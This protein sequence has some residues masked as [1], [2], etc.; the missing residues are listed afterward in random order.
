MGT[1]MYFDV[2]NVN[3]WTETVPAF[4][5]VIRLYLLM[6]VRELDSELA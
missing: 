4:D 2:L 6:F 1:K 3:A 5:L